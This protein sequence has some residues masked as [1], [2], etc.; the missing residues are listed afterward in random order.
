MNPSGARKSQG[1]GRV[2]TLGGILTLRSLSPRT[3]DGCKGS[4]APSQVL[5]GNELVPSG[6][7]LVPRLGGLMRVCMVRQLSRKE[8]AVPWQLEE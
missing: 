8:M 2:A 5:S 6:N 4:S 7:S 3:L 1:K